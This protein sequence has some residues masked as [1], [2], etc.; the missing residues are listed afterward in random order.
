MTE[1]G[2]FVPRRDRKLFSLG[3]DARDDWIAIMAGRGA[4]PDLSS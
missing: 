1:K 2:L 4:L 3:C